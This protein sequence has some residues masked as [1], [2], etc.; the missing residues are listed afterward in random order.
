MNEQLNK[1]EEWI[2][3]AL[4]NFA[5]DYFKQENRSS[6][7]VTHAIKEIIGNYGSE[8]GFE[9]CASGFPD[10]FHNEWLYDLVWYKE[11]EN[12]NLSSVELVLESEMRYGLPAIKFDFE[13]LLQSNSIHRIM[14]C[15]AGKT[16]IVDI[17]NYCNKAVDSYNYLKKGDKILTLIWDDFDSGKFIP[18]VTI[19]K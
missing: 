4:N 9:V 1:I 8:N 19:K 3:N 18:H 11:N 6:P 17:R 7:F 14:I 16:P 12:K 15:L 10:Y 13:K 5:D 2:V